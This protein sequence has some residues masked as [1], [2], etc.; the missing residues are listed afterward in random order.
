MPR[1][2]GAGD[3][4]TIDADPRGQALRTSSCNA[5]PSFSMDPP[6]R[7]RARSASREAAKQKKKRNDARAR[8]G[9][10]R[11]SHG[12]LRVF[13]KKTVAFPRTPGVLG[14]FA[15][16]GSSIV[17]RLAAA[18]QDRRRRTKNCSFRVAYGGTK[19]SCA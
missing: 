3:L 13:G 15:R 8:G 19:E 10:P 4:E 18:G 14:S 5:T 1:R 16:H 12:D 9:G 11:R 17:D 7:A 6:G 2:F